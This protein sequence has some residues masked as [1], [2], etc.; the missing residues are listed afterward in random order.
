M[1]FA[2]EMVEPYTTVL[3]APLGEQNPK[4]LQN[5]YVKFIGLSKR[6]IQAARGGVVGKITSSS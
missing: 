6:L 2:G 5:D 1:T 3:G 4:Y